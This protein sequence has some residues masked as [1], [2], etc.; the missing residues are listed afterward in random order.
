MAEKQSEYHAYMLRMWP[1]EE[2]WDRKLTT[3]KVWRVTLE[4]TNTHTR[5]GFADLEHAFEFLHQQVQLI[6]EDCDD[7][8]K[9][10]S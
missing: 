9:R 2:V 6:K 5:R 8:G 1:V 4:D 10:N 3:R 7:T